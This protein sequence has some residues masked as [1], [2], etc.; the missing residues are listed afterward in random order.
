MGIHPHAMSI[1]YGVS[2]A[3][4]HFLT[5]YLVKYFGDRNITVNAICPGFVDTP[6]QKNKTLD[7]RERIEDKIALGRFAEP[8]EIAQLV[9]SVLENGY[10]NGSI[11]NIDGGYDFK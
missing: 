6:W 10:I 5:K 8:E 4:L 3:G 9:N 11:L 2:K 1:S 7:H